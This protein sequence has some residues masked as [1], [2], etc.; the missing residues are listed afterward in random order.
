MKIY[1][2]QVF[3]TWSVYFAIVL[4]S[5]F[6]HEFGHCL[7]AWTHGY[8]AA[9]TPAK[10]YELET[11]PASLQQYVYLGGILGSVLV[12]IAVLI[13]YLTRTFKYNSAILAGALASPG[14]YVLFFILKGRGHDATEFQ[15]AQAAMGLSYSG[16]AVDWIFVILFLA[17]IIIWFS[18]TRPNY[19]ILGRLAIGAVLTF[20]F[21]IGLQ[22]LNNVIFDPIF[23]QK[24][25]P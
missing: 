4:L 8:R 1:I 16:H 25:V 14:V 6:V 13:L 9:I 5:V 12:V 15:E 23:Q 22:E 17:G 10:E 24:I 21:L 20:I 3:K 19:R 18:K 2:S 11:I 7:V